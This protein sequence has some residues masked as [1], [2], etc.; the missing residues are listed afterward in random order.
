ML[1]LAKLS[2]IAYTL[3]LERVEVGRDAAVLNV[4]HAS[5]GLIEKGAD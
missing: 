3:A 4:N 5:E 1:Y 2:N